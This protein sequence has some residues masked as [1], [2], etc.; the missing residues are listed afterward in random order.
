MK[1]LF[2]IS[3][4]YV[5][6][7]IVLFVIP[8]HS[9]GQIDTLH[10][11][12]PFYYTGDNG[13]DYNDHYAVLSTFENAP[14]KVTIQNNNAS[15]Y[16]EVIISKNSPAIIDFGN[17]FNAEGM[18]NASQSNTVL[19]TEGL[20]FTGPKGFFVNITHLTNLQG[21]IVTSK[22]TVGL[23]VDF[24][25]G[26]MYTVL[27]DNNHNNSRNR[28]RAQFISFMASENN[29]FVTVSNPNFTFDGH[30]SNTFTVVL[31]AGQ[32][33]L[34]KRDLYQSGLNNVSVNHINGT[35]ITS[36][37][38]I[39][40]N[41]GS[42]TAGADPG[43]RDIGVDQ[44]VP[45][46]IVGKEYI[47]CRGGG[48]NLSEN[49]IVVAT[50][51][52]TSVYLNG[53]S[54]AYAT[55]T[56]AGDYAVIPENQY[57]NG[58]DNLYIRADQAVY[59]FQSMAGSTSNATTGMYFIPRL[60]CNASKK[61]Q[62]SYADFLGNP[63]IKLVTQVGSSVTINGN[64]ITGAQSVQG[65]PNWVS[66][67]V[68]RSDL[69]NYNPGTD[70]NFTIESNG[71]LNAA[72]TIESNAIGAG[73]YY[74]GFGTV[75][76]ISYNPVITANGLCGSNVEFTASGY[77]EYKWYK[78]GEEILGETGSSY[79]ASSPGR[80]KVVG[81]TN[82][83]GQPSL[84]Y[85][86]NE[87]K[88]MPCLSVNPATYSITEGNTSEPN[89]NFTIEL[90][91][92]WNED[93]V[94]FYYETTG[95]TA[96][97]GK[98]FTNV[99][100]TGTITKGNTTFTVNVPILNDLLAE[101]DESFQITIS[102]PSNAIISE[103]T[104]VGIIADDGD[105]KPVI[106][107][108]SVLS[109]PEDTGTFQLNINLDRKSGQTITANYQINAGTAIQG[110][111]YSASAYS[112]TLSF[113][114][115]ELSKTVTISVINDNIDEPGAN[116]Q[117]QLSL[118]GITNAQTG[119][120]TAHLEIIDD[121]ETPEISLNSV[122]STEG[123]NVTINGTLS[124]PSAEQIEFKFTTLDDVAISPDDYTEFIDQIA[125]VN[126]GETSFQI[127]IPTVDD[128]ITEGTE[129]FNVYFEDLQN[130]MFSNDSTQIMFKAKIIDNDGKPQ[131]TIADVSGEEGTDFTFVVQ[132][133]HPS[134]TAITLQYETKDSTAISPADFTG[135]TT[136]NLTV[137]A[138]QLSK[139][140]SVSTSEDT[141]EEGNEFFK[142]LLQNISSNA[143]FD[144]STAVGT[145]ID[146][147]E[148]PV[149]KN[150]NYSLNEDNLLTDNVLL[151]D[152]GLGDIPVTISSYTNPVN[153]NLNIDTSTGEFTYQPD[154]N[155]FGKDTIF[156]TIQDADG[157]DSTAR[158][159]FT[160]ISVND[161][162]VAVSDAFTTPENTAVSGNV[163]NNDSGLGD[164]VTLSVKSNPSHGIV[165]MQSDGNFSYTPDEQYFGVDQ[166]TYEITDNNSDKASATVQITV[167]F[168]NDY[169]PVSLNDT[170]S[171]QEDVAVNIDV[172]SNDDDQDSRATLDIESVFIKSVPTNGSVS[173]IGGGIVTYTPDTDYTGNDVFTYTIRD[174]SGLESNVSTVFITVTAD[175]DPPVASCS[176][177]VTIYLDGTG[178]ATLPVDSA[179]NGSYDPDGDP[180]NRSLS[181]SAFG[182]S[183]I[184]VNT[185]TMTVEDS[186][187]AQSSCQ[188]NVHVLDTMAA[189]IVYA[190]NDTILY[191][192]I[193]ECGLVVN[194]N[195]PLFR[196]NS[197]GESNGTLVSGYSSGSVFTDTTTIVY[198]FTDGSGN[199]PA[200]VHFDV[201]VRD[202]I[203]PSISYSGST[204]FIAGAG[205][206][207]S[208]VDNSLNV[209]ATDNCS[210]ASLEHDFDGGGSTL[211]GFSIP[212]GIH[213]ISWTAR[214]VTNN[215]TTFTYDVEVQSPVSVSLASLDADTTVCKGEEIVF[216][217]SATG[218]NGTLTYDFHVDG[219]TLQSGTG[220]SFGISTLLDS[221]EV[222][223]VV[224]DEL[225]NSVESNII[226]VTILKTPGTDLIYRKP[227]N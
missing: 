6:I 216:E 130:A 128:I 159:I 225:L 87:V 192:G 88:I 108:P 196:D 33:Y 123:N 155:Y 48:S 169:N 164:G 173:V 193:G 165:T 45:I 53:N 174:I 166:F 218:G 127:A 185:V 81:I 120:V 103:G 66:Y 195:L 28:R 139:T 50:K 142:V 72:L 149:A 138:N 160:V 99:S 145:I 194:Y 222:K 101:D 100:G 44:I 102:S 14:F 163:L 214:D 143:D 157:D 36:N 179:D 188:T 148:T 152:V 10:Y 86:S 213:S 46:E 13:G 97:A 205:N 116:E 95:G 23:G 8:K 134:S 56:N 187:N 189:E 144:D 83:E 42:W 146:N 137:P 32:S 158:V 226:P 92:P 167:Q 22:G 26:H 96:A 223:V 91:H 175:N 215:I 176:G 89:V 63:E 182:A 183:D 121:D 184:G 70:W 35:H 7:I 197:D 15:F 64:N 59:V 29:T 191:A 171:T 80:Y 74:S 221:Q 17:K 181:K 79:S 168:S 110:S 220:N 132:V 49:V 68:P 24:F 124:N 125:T 153:G 52:N 119:N 71:A 154:A 65:N 206:E 16:Q 75:P 54:S 112:G 51:D 94:T 37:K 199:G 177:D 98:D 38:P 204:S 60:T 12:P 73:G 212:V 104:A 209:D 135:K 69:A 180:I 9:F 151:N 162:P 198:E 156:Y 40:V 115:E 186:F 126:S 172:A 131:V 219:V 170:I 161:I 140:F 133:S 208:V 178:Q 30:G 3:L 190:P 113:D 25:T 77:S 150:D 20:I 27:E 39:V 141:E 217:A 136:T 62:I 106:S 202:T 1:L 57:D 201:I 109:F 90:S 122:G 18:I 85:P 93:D 207:Y 105:P 43:L 227:N 61:V 41:S 210:V 31:H 147:D 200:Q 224:T 4:K 2:N 111:D 67:S 107:V 76:E 55:M 84:T 5:W 11:M 114:P 19:D 211:D 129:Q 117:F 58:T 47:L 34:I 82:C 78:D 203:S 118:S 21:M